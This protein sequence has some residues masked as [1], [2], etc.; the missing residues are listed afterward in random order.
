MA[1]KA[2]SHWTTFESPTTAIV[3]SPFSSPHWHIR[4]AVS[5]WSWRHLS[6]V[7][8]GNDLGA[9]SGAGTNHSTSSSR[10]IVLSSCSPGTGPDGCAAG[11][12][13]ELGNVI[14]R[15]RPAA[16]PSNEKL[17]PSDNAAG[18]EALIDRE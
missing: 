13:M 14:M 5:C 18:L 2:D 3:G 10:S 12:T 7:E 17:P 15:A 9:S 1:S 11:G 4:T 6:P 16:T 8:G